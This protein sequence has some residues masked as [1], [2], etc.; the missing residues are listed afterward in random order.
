MYSRNLQPKKACCSGFFGH[1]EVYICAAFRCIS[2]YYLKT[3]FRHWVSA[4]RRIM[5]LVINLS[6]KTHNPSKIRKEKVGSGCESQLRIPHR[7]KKIGQ[8][9]IIM[10]RLTKLVH[11][12]CFILIDT[13]YQWGKDVSALWSLSR[14][15][16]GPLITN[17]SQPHQGASSG[18]MQRAKVINRGKYGNTRYPEN[19]KV[20]GYGTI[21]LENAGFRRMVGIRTYA[22]KANIKEHSSVS[23]SKHVEENKKNP[24]LMND[25]T[26]HLIG[27][28]TTLLLAYEMIKSNPGQMTRGYTGETLDGINLSWFTNT[29]KL[30]KAGKYRFSPSRRINIPKPGRQERRPLTIG[31]PRDKVVQKAI[32]LVLEPIYEPSF[33]INSHGFRPAKGCHTALKQIK[34]WFHGVTW[35]IESDISKC[36]PSLDHEILITLLRKRISCDK[37]IAL[38]K[39]LIEAGY[40][41]LSIFSNNKVGT[42]QG[43]ILSPLLCNIYLQE[44]DQFLYDLKLDF[45][46]KPS[47]ERRK[48]PAYRKIQYE[49]SKANRVEDKKLLAKNLK[50]LHSKDFMDPKFRK[51]FYVRYADDFIIGVTGSFTEAEDILEKVR[52]FL[53]ETLKLDLSAHK[54]SIVH[55]KRKVIHFLGTDIYGASR[56]EK[57]MRTVKHPG[58][59][60][61]IKVRVTPKVGMHA[62]IR[63]LLE[64]LHANKILKR[65][66]SGVYVPT[67]LRR[68]IN[69][70]HADILGYYNSISRGIL[71]YYSFVDNY[72]RLNSIVKY[73]LLHSCALTLALKYKLRHRSKAFK[74]FGSQ[75]KDKNSDKEFVI[76]D[77][78]HRK[79][80]FQ[81][82]PQQVD[83]VIAKKWNNKLSRSN[84]NKACVIC[85]A[86]PAEMHHVR[87]IRDLEQKYRKGKID[88]FTKQMAA[89]NRKQIPLCKIHHT[90][91][92]HNKLSEA[93]M[94]AFTE[95][96]QSLKK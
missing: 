86:F 44:L 3:Q 1:P 65:K 43:S 55:F 42:Q 64:R 36:F 82:N 27:D 87:K 80:L 69:F 40:V 58:W 93:E 94:I 16:Q 61:S 56:K 21:I 20:N 29:S 70:E 18:D 60:K 2:R 79:N 13:C 26:I 90:G 91:V 24:S 84:I 33:F 23:L 14:M 22:E 10:R 54:T 96:I 45:S 81:I 6:L 31:S 4:Y 92:H 83:S 34:D 57:P 32:Q 59:G 8:V 74:R 25:K 39:N 30:I 76:P 73:H 19:R 63:K 53:S 78:F 38:I 85:G 95:G 7:F 50:G 5:G 12:G 15:Y 35:V 89:I 67:A 41:D 62:P 68:L 9:R 48:N 77:N 47:Y 52:H 75:L 71:N 46:S 51:L 11:V 17:A 88:F 37:T 28:E 66:K 49:L 72:G